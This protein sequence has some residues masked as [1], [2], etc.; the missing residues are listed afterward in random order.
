MARSMAREL[1][2]RNITANVV[3]PGPVATEMLASLTEEQRTAITSQV[4]LGR[5]A[6]PHEIAEAVKFLA[7]ESAA[8]ITGAVIPVDGGL[9]MGH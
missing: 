6:Q 1:G 7:S 9:G 8:Y 5:V 3:T 4:P 2:S